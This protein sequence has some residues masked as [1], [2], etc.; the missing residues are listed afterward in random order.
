[1]PPMH[2][3]DRKPAVRSWMNERQHRTRDRPKGKQ[4]RY[5]KGI[6]PEASQS[7]EKDVYSMELITI[8]N[9]INIVT[10]PQDIFMEYKDVFKGLS[11]LPGKC[12][13][14]IN[15]DAQHVKHTPGRIAT[16]LKAELKAY[17]ETLQ[18]NG[19][20]QESHRAN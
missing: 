10:A 7:E 12:H 17:I 11:C 20:S 5:F 18:K 13:L 8:S 9:S 15:H 16:L 1:M 19:G 3:W 2:H 6:F 14:Q 4:P